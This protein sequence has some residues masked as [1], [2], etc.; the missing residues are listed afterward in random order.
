[1]QGKSVVE[2]AKNLTVKY[3]DLFIDDRKVPKKM[4]CLELLNQIKGHDPHLHYEEIIKDALSQD[5]TCQ[6]LV[7]P[8][9]VSIDDT[10]LEKLLK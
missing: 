3:P 5:G 4:D 7:G 1:M 2:A 10:R 8:R 6:W 9:L